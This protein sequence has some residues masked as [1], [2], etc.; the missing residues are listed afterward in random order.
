MSR[1][2]EFSDRTWTVEPGW[3]VYGSDGEKIG[4]VADIETHYFRVEKGWLFKTDIYVPATAITDSSDGSVY[5]NTTKDRVEDMGWDQP[6]LDTTDYDATGMASGT[7]DTSDFGT[8]GRTDY[9][10]TETDTGMTSGTY[11]TTERRADFD[12]SDTVHIPVTEEELRVRKHAQERGRVRIRKDVVEE[13]QTMNVPVREEEVHVERHRV[14]DTT[15]AGNVP[16]DAFQERDIEVPVYGED[17]DVSKERVVRE[18]VDVSKTA[19][20]RDKRVSETVR[21]EEVHVEGEDIDDDQ[22]RTPM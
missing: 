7:Y 5:L 10:T 14:D 11:D 4:N 3:D 19:R 21:R 6:P 22:T 15:R 1:N 2:D 20:E 17:V 18:E 9:R 8:T 16:S 12:E 13:Q